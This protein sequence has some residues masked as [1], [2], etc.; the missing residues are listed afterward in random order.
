MALDVSNRLIA[1]M[2]THRIAQEDRDLVKM[3]T[4]D[5]QSLFPQ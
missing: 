5:G 4:K 2:S 1:Q 3:L